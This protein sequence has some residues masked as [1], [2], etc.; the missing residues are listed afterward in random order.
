MA[1]KTWTICDATTGDY[2]ETLAI[3]AR[4]C[5]LGSDDVLSIT[6][7]TL[8][9]G[10]S[11]G[12]DVVE[13]D[14]GAIC[15]SV[16]PTRGMGLGGLTLADGRSIAWRSPIRGPVHPQFVHL[17]DPSGLGWLDG[18]DEFL[19][20][21]GLESNGAP[22][23]DAAGKLI[24]PLH[25]KIANRPA[26]RVTVSFD[27]ATREI[28]LTGEV[29]EARFLFAKFRLTTTIRTRLGESSLRIRDEVTN[30]GATAAEMQLL[31]HINFGGALLGEGARVVA[32]IEQLAPRNAHAAVDLDRWDV[33]AAPQAGFVEQVYFLRLA[34][35]ADGDSQVLLR[36]RDRA[37]GASVRAN[38]GQLPCFT[39]W[40]NTAAVEDGYVT[41]L[42]PGTNY[43]NPRS[44]EQQQG[45]TVRLEAGQ[46]QAFDVAVEA[47][48]TAAAVQDAEAAIARLQAGRTPQIHADP[49][50]GWC[51]P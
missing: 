26:R 40:K 23:F 5:G 47:H 31:Y 46:Q 32:P 27:D 16:L 18:F 44:F 24:H 11:D 22:E 3:G 39:L 17:Y 50:A 7:R 48:A 45:R 6:K 35:D 42:E 15:F 33:Y 29:D 51:A 4:D 49:P 14:N 10:L 36:G 1:L 20:R 25:G 2:A 12:V 19:C 30:V 41:G 43:P 8:R 37:L 38:V 13:I 9:G 28:V 21:C 34:A